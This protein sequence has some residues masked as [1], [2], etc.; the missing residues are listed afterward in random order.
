MWRLLQ[1]SPFKERESAME[2][3]HQ[4]PMA[5]YHATERW[6]EERIGAM[7][8]Y[9]SDGRWG[10]AFDEF[11][12]RHLAIPRYDR[13][14]VPGGPAWI[15]PPQEPAAL[16]ATRVQL[17]FL[18]KTHDLERIV[19]ITHYGCAWYGHLLKRPPDACLKAQTHDIEA[20]AQTL[21][22]WYPTLSIEAYLAMRTNDW[23][24]FHPVELR[25]GTRSW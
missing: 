10:A 3:S 13:W 14:A 11:C 24:S 1:E 25:S 7:A 6:N 21:S 2:L 22:D 5:A 4:L 18:V 9:C 12:H 16:A 23:L 15:A 20:A 19:L 8:I 17:D